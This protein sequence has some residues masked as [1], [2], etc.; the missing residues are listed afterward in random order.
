MKNIISATILCTSLSIISCASSKNQTIISLTQT[1][2][3]QT[4]DILKEEEIKEVVPPPKITTIIGIKGLE[5]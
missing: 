4:N 2:K 3:D 5:K 1:I